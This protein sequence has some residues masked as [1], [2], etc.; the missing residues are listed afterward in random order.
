MNERVLHTRARDTGANRIVYWIVRAILQLFF[1]TYFRMRRIGREHLPACGAVIVA[2]NHRSL[3]DPFVIATMAR[4]PMYYVTKKELSRQKWVAWLLGAFGAFPV[5]R[6]ASD[7]ELIT[8][9]KAILARGDVVLIFPEGTRI[10]PGS[11]GTPKLGVGRLAL[12]TGAPV[13]PVAVLGTEAVRRG[14]RIRPHKVTIR[15]GRP[16]RFPQLEGA[17]PALAHA[18]TARIWPSVMLHGSGSEVCHRSVARNLCARPKRR[19][20]PRC[21]GWNQAPDKGRT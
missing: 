10:R 21:G 19:Y 5:D 2:A 20:A 17:S 8:T 18:V 4:R 16:L 1:L 9:A 11:L 12:E 7:A 6:G 13:V 14:W 15:A 3:L